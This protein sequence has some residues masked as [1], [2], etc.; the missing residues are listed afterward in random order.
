MSLEA[1]AL[2]HGVSRQ[3][4]L[5]LRAM[6][7]PETD[8]PALPGTSEAAIQN[9]VRLEAS[10]R[11]CR[12]FRNNVGAGYLEDG[13]FVR[14][15]LANDSAALNSKVKSADL[16]GIRPVLITPEH[17]GKVIGQFLSREVKAGGWRYTGTDREKAQLKWA[18]L[19]TA[20]GG[21]AC[22]AAGKGTI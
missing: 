18:E 6:M 5:E 17:V 9:Q 20:M 14:W 12:L 8:P 13:S 1:W 11:G 7:T 15:G 4:L 19:I 16:I 21:D 2:R 3:A 22:F 10:A